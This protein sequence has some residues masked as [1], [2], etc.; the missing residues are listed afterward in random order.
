VDGWVQNTSAE[1]YGG[2]VYSANNQPEAIDGFYIR[3]LFA[4]GQAKELP[5]A[6]Y[7]SIGIKVVSK[8]MVDNTLVSCSYKT[9]NCK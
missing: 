8:M 4:G 2:Y 6:R 7:G 1:K 9:P 5:V 3:I